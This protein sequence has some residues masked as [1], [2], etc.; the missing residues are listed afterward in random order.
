MNQKHY[1]NIFHAIVNINFKVKNV[2]K[3]KSG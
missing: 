2:I 1:Q 3:I